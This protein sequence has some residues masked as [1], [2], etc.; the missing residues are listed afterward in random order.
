MNKWIDER[1]NSPVRMLMMVVLIGAFMLPQML[2]SQE[3][4]NLPP[5]NV[6]EHQIEDEKEV[7]VYEKLTPEEALSW[8]NSL[9][10]NELVDFIIRWDFIEHSIPE[11]EIEYSSIITESD[12]FVVPT[13]EKTSLL[14]GSEKD[15][16]N[17]AYEVKLPTFVFKN[18]IKKPV[19]NFPLGFGIG[20]VFG[21]LLGSAGAFMLLRTI[22]S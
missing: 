1:K 10:I 16:L 17:L 20:T 22:G 7:S 5:L 6:A 9:P 19:N 12:L 3:G 15:N 21:I 18:V 4:A 14:I 11:M 13:P 2:F 8:I